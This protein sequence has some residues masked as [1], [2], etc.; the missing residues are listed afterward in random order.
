MRNLQTDDGRS[1]PL[2]GDSL[3]L[4][5]GHLLC[6][7]MQPGKLVVLHVEDIIDLLFRDDEEMT[8]LNGLDVKEGKM[9]VIL[10][11]NVSGQLT[12]NNACKDTGHKTNAFNGG[13]LSI[14]SVLIFENGGAACN[15]WKSSENLF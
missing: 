15:N 4:C 3:L 5:A 10:G 6:E 8:A 2:A 14:L 12:T 13:S 1:D 9:I 7:D 11:D